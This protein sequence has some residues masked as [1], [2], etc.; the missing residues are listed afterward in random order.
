LDEYGDPRWVRVLA[1]GIAAAVAAFGSVGLLLAVFGAYS[2]AVALIAGSVAFAGLCL[3]GRPLLPDPGE[4]SGAARV[5]AALAVVAVIAITAWNVSNASQQVLVIRD[6]GTYLNAG[7]WVASH[8]TLEVKPFTGPFSTRS[9]LTAS[10]AGMSRNGDHL[11]F[12]LE[13]MVPVLL[14]EAQNLGGDRLMYATVPILGGAAL[15]AFYLL[16]RR[17]LRYPVAALGAMLGLGLL[18]PQVSFSRDS[19]TEIPMQV[20]L[21][22]AAWLLCDRRTLR[23]RGTAFTAGLFLGLLQAMHIDGLAFVIGL[24]FAALCWWSRASRDER[25]PI[26]RSV[27]WTALGLAVGVGLGFL[28]LVLRSPHYFR[29]LDFDVERLAAVAL[30]A[31]GAALGIAMLTRVWSQ[32]APELRRAQEPVAGLAAVLVL[33]GGFGAWL[34]RPALQTVRARRASSVVA[35]VQRLTHLTLDPTRRYFEHSVG[36]TSWYLGPITL[37]LAIVG[38]ALATRSFVRGTLR[39]QSQVAA[40]MLAPPALLYLWRPSITPD[41]IWAMRRFLPAVLP[42]LV[43]A[44]FGTFCVLASSDARFGSPY[45]RRVVAVALGLLAVAY[46]AYTIRHVSQM[47]QQRGFPRAVEDACRIVG[48]RGAVIVPQETKPLTWLYDP[49]TLRSFCDVPVGISRSDGTGGAEL[50]ANALRTLARQWAREDRKLFI[51]AGSRRA[52]AELFPGANVRTVRA[53]TNPHLLVQTL[54]RRPDAYNPETLAFA[55]A[56]VPVA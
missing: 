28:D 6:G 50:D 10:S 38:A 51:V 32:R 33:V 56:R 7:K 11:D 36:W 27:L 2:G 44:A 34:A 45:A 30:V 3:L 26:A 41:Q 24:P 54:V 55:I 48:P 16:A 19:T 37:T 17:V 23:Q 52:I 4:A 53:A 35:T 49:Q 9:G 15:L 20:L 46:P 31:V 1:F 39:V 14:A 5:C 47:T 12:T 43:L 13:H 42:L 8:G 22:S 18:M 21:F 29:T 40:V 25:P